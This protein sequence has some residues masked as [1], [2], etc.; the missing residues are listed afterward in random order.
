MKLLGIG[1]SKI[2][3]VKGRC[4]GRLENRLHTRPHSLYG[5]RYT[6]RRSAI[7]VG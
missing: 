1:D 5:Y 3:R 4:I 7:T 6:A 2:H